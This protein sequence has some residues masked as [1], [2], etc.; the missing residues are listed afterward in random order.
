MV[1]SRLGLLVSI[2]NT[3][4]EESCGIAG[5]STRVSFLD[6]YYLPKLATGL[7]T[8]GPLVGLD[9]FG[10]ELDTALTVDIISEILSQSN[11]VRSMQTLAVNDLDK[12]GSQSAWNIYIAPLVISS[13]RADVL[14]SD[15]GDDTVE[16]ILT[17]LQ[18]VIYYTQLGMFHEASLLLRVTP[19][20]PFLTRAKLDRYADMLTTANA[21]R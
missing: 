10:N 4:A 16:H 20:T 6:I 17:T 1:N 12:F 8:G 21:I 2:K 14:Y 18:P 5:N 9:L 11:T 7:F 3:S 19:P 15:I 13:V